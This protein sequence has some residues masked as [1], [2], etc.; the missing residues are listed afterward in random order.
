MDPKLLELLKPFSPQLRKLLDVLGPLPP[1][2]ATLDTGV[3]RRRLSLPP[4][5]KPLRADVERGLVSLGAGLTV[6]QL[7]QL[8]QP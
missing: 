4:N 5:Y 2:I 6:P 8:R 1:N 7:L 3:R